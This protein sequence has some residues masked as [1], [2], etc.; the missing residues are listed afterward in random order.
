[1]GS[2][3]LKFIVG[4]IAGLLAWMMFEPS[5]PKTMT[6]SWG[7][8][9][10][11][12]VMVLGGIIGLAVGGLDGFTRGGKQHTIRGLLLGALLGAVGASFGHG[13]GGKVVYTVF[14]SAVFSTAHFITAIPA[15]IVAF[16]FIGTALGAAIGAAS[17]NVKKI[18][19]GAIGGFIGSAIA[20]AL[21]DIVSG[22]FGEFLLRAQGLDR[23]EV[24]TPGRAVMAVLL[25]A[26]I[27]LFIGIVDRLSRSAWLRL[28]LGRNEGKEWSIDSNQ[29]FIGRSEGASVPLFGDQNI[30]PIHASIQRQNGQYIL[31]DGGS[32]IG[33]LLNGQRIQQAPLFHGAHIQIGSFNLEFLMKNMAAPARG[34]EAYPGQAYP[35]QGMPMPQQPQQPVPQ[36]DGMSPTQVMPQQGFPQPVPQGMP[37]QAMPGMGSQP[38]MAY[39]APMQAG[40]RQHTLVAIDGPLMGQRFPVHGPTDLGRECPAIPMS[41]DSAASRRHANI[42]PGPQ[43]LSVADAGSTNG[44][45]VNGQRV[46]QAMAGPGD[47]IKVGSTT[48]RVEAA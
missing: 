35:L 28:V 17:L 26:G 30:A 48:F 21:F 11:T 31:V 3:L 41:F 19:Q 43:G 33:T 22:A 16:V 8:W 12:Y 36:P 47:L 46:S 39:G 15:R 4:G 40:P 20:G 2:L 37:T 32:P 27:A 29:T 1:M 6:S 23:G 34:P 14:G 38:T 25:G 42:S 44:T 18:I 45:F 24:G 10:A 7:A 5:A 9:E 13:L